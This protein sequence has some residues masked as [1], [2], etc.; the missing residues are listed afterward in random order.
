MNMLLRGERGIRT[1]Y[2]TVLNR[3][4]VPDAKFGPT[5]LLKIFHW[6]GSITDTTL[7]EPCARQERS[8]RFSIRMGWAR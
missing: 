2:W 8:G 3:A 7:H 1:R 4:N 5:Y 6:W